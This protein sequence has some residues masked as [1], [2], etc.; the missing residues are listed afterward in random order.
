M[1]DEQEIK[2]LLLQ[3]A[4]KNAQAFASLYALTAPI[5]LGIA[6]RIVSRK[7]LAEEVLQDVFVKIWH[8]ASQFDPLSNQPIGW[9][10]TM[11]RNR[12]LDIVGSADVSRV[13][14]VDMS[15]QHTV[16][17]LDELLG[18]DHNHT[19][20]ASLEE[21]RASHHVLRQCVEGLP[22]IEKQTIALAFFH[23]LSHQELADHLAKPLGSVKTWVRRGMANLKRC[24]S[25]CQQRSAT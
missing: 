12:A 5:M 18:A 20:P 16:A 25:D 7:E 1:L 10:A 15:D 13:H 21:T 9:I 23:G 11:T 3:T 17:I 14:S 19:D 24:V 2:T 8:R 6:Q 22:P 4:G